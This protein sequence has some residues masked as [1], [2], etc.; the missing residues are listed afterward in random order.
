MKISSRLGPHV[1]SSLK[2][3]LAIS[4]TIITLASAPGASY[5]AGSA[6]AETFAVTQFALDFQR[7][8]AAASVKYTGRELP[9]NGI[10]V[11]TGA[12]PTGRPYV[13]LV[14]SNTSVNYVQAWTV[15]AYAQISHLKPG[16]QVDMTCTAYSRIGEAPVLSCGPIQSA[17][18]VPRTAPVLSHQQVCI[19]DGSLVEKIAFGRDH[20]VTTTDM[21]SAINEDLQREPGFSPFFRSHMT[22]IVTW[23]YGN[24][25]LDKTSAMES[26]Y[27]DCMKRS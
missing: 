3:N 22:S 11:N 13:K 4:V 27:D 12:D 8:A 21:Q 20:G 15:G 19:Y 5:S 26:Y 2:I 14:G 24:P 6:H 17:S 18:A 10:V 16:D 23:V 7:D 1:K 9:Y 25:A